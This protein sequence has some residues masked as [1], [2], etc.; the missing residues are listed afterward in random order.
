MR[1]K[2]S[3]YITKFNSPFACYLHEL[4]LEGLFDDEQGDVFTTIFWFGKNHQHALVCDDL[5]FVTHIRQNN[6]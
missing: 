1:E 3:N 4:A 6:N 2:Y 5:G